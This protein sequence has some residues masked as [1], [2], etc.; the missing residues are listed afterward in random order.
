MNYGFAILHGLS[1]RVRVTH[2][3]GSPFG[4]PG[5][6]RR[7]TATERSDLSSGLP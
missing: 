2:V 3:A 1:H 6:G 5:L 7:L 4:H